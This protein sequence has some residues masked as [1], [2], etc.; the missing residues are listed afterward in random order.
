MAHKE[1]PL[2]IPDGWKLTPAGTKIKRTFK[3]DNYLNS[4]LFVARVSIHA[5][6]LKHHPDIALSYGKVV[7]T[8]CTHETKSVTRKDIELAERINRYVDNTQ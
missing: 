6:V 5:E 7:V 4:F 2:Q 8:L 1:K 3:F